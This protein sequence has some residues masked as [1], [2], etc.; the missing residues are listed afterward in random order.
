MKKILFILI[1]IFSFLCH[2]IHATLPYIPDKSIIFEKSNTGYDLYIKRPREIKS[3]LLTESQK[4]PSNK[5]VNF[6]IRTKTFH[7]CNGDELRI[8]DK[9]ILHTK[10]DLFFLVDSTTQKI[11][12]EGDYFHFFLPDE[13]IY[14][15]K[16]SRQGVMNIKPGV[17]INLRLFAKKYADYSGEF[18]DQWITLKL[19]QTNS[20]YRR[21]LIPEFSKFCEQTNGDLVI[22]DRNKFQDF[23]EKTLPNSVPHEESTDIVFIIDTTLSMKEELPLFKYEYDKIISQIK[24]KSPILRIA[25]VLFKDYGD[26]YV[27]KTYPFTSDFQKMKEIV[28]GLYAEG[29]DDIP[30]AAYEAIFQ[31]KN[32]DFLS[33]NRLL[34]L[35]TDAPPHTDRGE[36]VG[37]KT[38]NREDAMN[39][40]KE[41]KVKFFSVCIPY[42]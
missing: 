18:K 42:R 21:R 35:I 10:Y 23:L 25:F 8:L 6:G 20:D 26:V 16:W 40:I 9:K 30:E 17:R 12:R 19:T 41:K 29:G 27:V 2:L 13:V 7:P 31:I 32:L 38:I 1:L 39:I 37:E 34:Y 14:G 3:I 5:R 24:N 15:Y 4:D 22:V 11:D 36:N 33:Q 28:K